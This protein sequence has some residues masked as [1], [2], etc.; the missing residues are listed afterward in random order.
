MSEKR[1]TIG[2]EISYVAT[3]EKINSGWRA[4]HVSVATNW[5]MDEDG[6]HDKSLVGIVEKFNG[7]FGTI[8]G[9]IQFSLSDVSLEEYVPHVGDYVT[10]EVRR[11]SGLLEGSSVKPLRIFQKEGQ[12]LAV[13]Q[14]HGYI[15]G[16]TFFMMTACCESY[17]PRK[18]DR[19]QTVVIESSQGKCSWRAIS[20][21][22]VVVNPS[23]R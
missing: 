9:Q 20:L 13:Q 3:R 12:I 8:N 16:D 2:E 15:D 23:L 4:T 22:P 7:E 14:D 1:L 10:L 19:V 17:R 18:W 11:V 6:L 21:S 5:E